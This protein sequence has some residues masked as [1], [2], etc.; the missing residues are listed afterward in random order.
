MDVELGGDLGED[1]LEGGVEVEVGGDGEVNVVEC[2][3]VL[4]AALGFFVEGG[5][6]D[7]VGGDFGEG[8]EQAQVGLGEGGLAQGEQDA[9]GQVFGEEGESGQ[10][11]VGG[12]LVAEEEE[13]VL[14]GILGEVGLAGAEG[15]AP[16]A[17]VGRDAQAAQVSEG[18]ADVVE[19]DLVAGG[20][21][22]TDGGALGLEEGMGMVEDGGDD[23]VVGLGEAQGGGELGNA[24]QF[25]LTLGSFGDVHG[26]LEAHITSIYPADDAV[27]QEMVSLSERVVVF[28]N[29]GFTLLFQNDFIGA[30]FA[31]CFFPLKFSIT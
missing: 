20:V 25:A 17:L 11:G 14:A 18:A 6:V 21:E 12:D 26:E 13:G 4:E 28:P 7:G 27:N 16:D 3:E 31:G 9:D 5:A 15:D 24:L 8:G 29:M 1:D 19:G 23:L 10:A 30:E 2:G 22:Q